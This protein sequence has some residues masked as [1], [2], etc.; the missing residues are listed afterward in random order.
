MNSLKSPRQA[1]VASTSHDNGPETAPQPP[2]RGEAS[3]ST[4][5]PT[6]AP[7]PDPSHP[8]DPAPQP[9][10]N[11]TPHPP[12]SD[13][14]EPAENS[15]PQPTDPAAAVA[16]PAPPQPAQ[17]PPHPQYPGAYAYGHPQATYPHAPYYGGY[18]YPYA[19]YPPMQPT[20]HPQPPPAPY[21]PQP[22]MYQNMVPMQQQPQHDG[23][24]ADDLPSYE[25]MIV[26]ALTGCTDPE[27]WAPKDLF[28]WMATR[29]PLQ[30][31]FRPS[32]SQALQKAFKRGRFE[33]S[34]NGKYR[35][36][37]TWNGGNVSCSK[38]AREGKETDDFG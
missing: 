29:Y 38:I 9:S 1:E 28:A 24:A 7:A 37:A 21:P 6:P 15:T 32:A 20:Y 27:G 14:T 4:S 12:A 16:Q 34:S 33:K 31:N 5:A 23:A 22:P 10:G 3:P 30:S 18:S 13:S 8:P 36:N 11:T 17:P 2:D 19:S 35:L 25:E 26:E